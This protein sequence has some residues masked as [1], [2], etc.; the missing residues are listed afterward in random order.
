MNRVGCRRARRGSVM[1]EFALAGVVILTVLPASVE[2]CIGLWNYH[3]LAYA[4]HEAAR[5]AASHG[6]GCITGTSSCGISVGNI[7]TKL[8]GS[9]IGLSSSALNVTLVTDSG[10]STVCNP[11]TS[12]TGSTTRWPPSSNMDNMTGKKVV[13]SATY[14]FTAGAVMVWPGG[15]SMRFNTFT[16]PSM[17]TQTIIF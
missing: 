10:A 11:I 3:T 14:K 5:Y 16:F 15:G 7:M 2:L 6:R 12:C 8:T 13:V 17:A 9:A 1:V 4:V